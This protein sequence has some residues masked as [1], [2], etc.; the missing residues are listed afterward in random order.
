MRIDEIL[1]RKRTLS[2]E[3][4]PPKKDGEQELEKLFSTIDGLNNLNPDF[5]SVTYGASGTAARCSAEVAGHIKKIGGEPL[6]HVTG[7][8]SSPEDIDVLANRLKDMNVENVL[9]LRGDKP[10]EYVA[11]YC[12]HFK[13]ASDLADYL[14][15]YGFCIGAACYPEGHVESPTLYSDLENLKKKVQSGAAFFITQ[16]F[17]DNAYY[18]RLVNEA[19]KSG[20]NI[21]IIP[22]IMPFTSVKNFSVI[23]SMCG[24]TIPIELKNMIEVYA[25]NPAALREAGINYAVNQIC[26]LVAKGAPG[27]HIYTMNRADTAVEICQRLKHVLN[28]YFVAEK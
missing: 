22:G 20:I 23:K 3:V 25:P 15:K 12:K 21:P 4:F 16:M 27:I 9:A 14:K 8:P 7:G 26:D 10:V 18:Y 5:I 2:F 19:R 17:F 28:G 1:K 24:S 13:H 11:E 6:A